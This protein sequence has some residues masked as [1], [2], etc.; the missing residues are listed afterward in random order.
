MVDF[1]DGMKRCMDVFIV[2]CF[3]MKVNINGI[4]CIVV[5]FDFLVELGFVEGNGKNVVVF[6]GNVILCW[7]DRVVLWGSEFIVICI[8]CF[9]GKL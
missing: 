3:G 9:N 7:G 1:F 6:L 5:E 8:W 2:E 4:D